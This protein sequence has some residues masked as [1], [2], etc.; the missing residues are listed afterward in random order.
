MKVKT[1]VYA[2]LVLFCA[3]LAIAAPAKAT[4]SPAEAAREILRISGRRGGLIVHLG[5]G[6]GRL[7]AALGAAGP[8]LVHGLDTEPASIAEAR[9]RIRAA[10]LYGRVSVHQFDGSALPYAENLVNLL[11]AEDTARVPT[12]EVMRVLAPNGVA[13]LKND[14][15]WRKTVKTWPKEMDEWTHHLHDASGNAVGEDLIVGPPARMQ[16]TAGP[17]WAR[18][19]GWTPSVSA[20]V[21]AGGRL[22]CICDETPAGVD[23]SLPSRWAVVARDGFSGVLLWRRPIAE[24]GSAAFSGTPDTGRGV[25]T[26]RFTMPPNVGKRLVA[27][28]SRV[29]VTLGPTAPVTALDAVSGRTVRVYAGTDN[30][31]EFILS[32]GRLIVSINPKERIPDAD[33]SKHLCAVDA[34]SGRGLWQRGPF[35]AIRASKAQDPFG[36]LE[37]CAGG[38][39]VFVLTT[40]AINCLDART[41]ERLWRTQ[42]PALPPDAVR[43]VGFAGMYE[44]KLTVMVYHDGVVLLA[45]PEPNTH[46]TYHTM[47]GTLYAFGAEDGRAMWKHPYGGWGHCTPPDVFVMGRTVWTH[48][49]AKAEYSSSW[50]GGY[51]AK[52]PSQVNYR[53]QQLDL[54]TGKLLKEISTRDIFNVGH[55]HRCYR[56]K[57]T[58]RF[59]MSCRRGVEF[60]DLATGQN[61]QN[62]WVRSGCLLGYV[63]CNGLLYVT[64]HPC[65][66]YIGA[67]LTGFNAL[68]PAG[69]PTTR[70][71]GA[72]S[73]ERLVRGRAYDRAAAN[74]SREGAADAWP[75]YRHDGLRTGA[76]DS[77]VAAA[78][79]PAWRVKLGARPS[80]AVAAGGKVLAAAIDEHTVYAFEAA[81]GEKIWDYTAD[82][83]V[84]SPPTLY[85]GRA[86]FG[87]ADG[88]VYCLDMRDGALVWRFDAAPGQ[89]LIT[90]FGQLESAWPVPSSV[91]VTAEG[92]CWFAAG[93]SS[94]LDGG[95]R[96]YALDALTG[97]LLDHRTVYSPDPKTGIMSPEPS[98][99]T[100]A[101]LLNDIP[102][103]DGSGVF[104]RQMQLGTAD[105]RSGRHIWTTAG[106]LDSSWF[107]R[108]FWQVGRARTT[109]L[110]VLGADAAYGVEVY[111]AGGRDTVFTA[112]AGAYRLRCIPLKTPAGASAE[113]RAAIKRRKTGPRARWEQKLRIRVTGLVRAADVIFAAG[114][115]DVVEPEDPYAAWQGRKGAI[116]AAFSSTDGS[117]LGEWRLSS[118]PVFDGLIAAYGRLYLAQM[119]GTLVCLRAK[120]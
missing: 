51:R 73:D 79:E 25:T 120:K 34:E 66:C 68:A 39:K 35:S 54:E 40:E 94:Y 3:G 115:P 14:G 88:R 105:E 17:L 100:V 65:G 63:P 70:T 101:G 103:G 95:I 108:T 47:P 83:R 114:A 72:G 36:R 16:W 77:P 102:A 24:W 90:A 55:H 84:D 85:A 38:G 2:L 58:Q 71:S 57:S 89:R 23:S 43:R 53:I 20:M 44:Y 52:D 117:K 106:Y 81:R 29:Y 67:K 11:V 99:N 26:G 30:A 12:A 93:R 27:A 75:T 50:G 80:A 62:H 31:D 10:G 15:S 7:T 87:S 92:K 5:C 32:D 60:V 1:P 13:C 76:T 110:M 74:D 118:P 9:A 6:D 97:R 119:D 113:S 28:G 8:F 56:N 111:P 107:N 48:V 69:P 41:G 33:P 49:H 61:Y 86:I 112:G 116:L 21:S 45:Q 59:L 19:H 4:E 22:F 82:A 104:I 37:L 46:H 109:G 64:P 18:S 91:L 42:R 96:I 98:P 78:L